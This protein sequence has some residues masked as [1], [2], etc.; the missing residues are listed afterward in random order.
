MADRNISQALAVA[1]FRWLW[2]GTLGSSF[3]MNMQIIARG[4]LVYTLTSSALDLAWVTLSFMIP[5]VALSLPGGVLADRMPKRAIIAIAQ[6]MNSVATVIMGLIIVNGHVSFW[7]FIWFGFFNGSVLALSMPARQAFVPELIPEQLIFTAM[8]LNTTSWNL[9]RILGPALA[10]FLIAMFA[11]GDT[12]SAHGVG[13]VYFMIAALYFISAVTVMMVR[14]RG[15]SQQL[16][17]QV[18]AFGDM[19]DGLRYVFANPPIFGL[20]MLSLLPFLFGMPLNTLLP[21]F[22]ED[23]LGGG[24]DDL[25]LLMSAMGAGAITGSLMLAWIGD[26]RHKAAWLISTCV[27]WGAFTS[28]FGLAQSVLLASFLVGV[29]GFLS[30]W[31]M[32]LNRGLMQMQVANHMRGRIMSIDMMSHGLMPL[33]V[34]PISLIAEAYDVAVALVVAGIVFMVSVLA[35]TLVSRSVRRVDDPM[36][37]AAEGRPVEP[38]ARL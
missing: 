9:S 22:N 37:I 7:D 21:A 36:P 14:K 26:V 18:S 19:A 20:I 27:G 24:P 13:I 3:A 11:S 30:A 8:A 32:S 16:Q 12:S 35:L 38:G 1:D 29:I 23:I 6:T 34:I 31:N 2:I 10:G 17:T 28:A 15:L 4:W 25:G 33:G 5:T